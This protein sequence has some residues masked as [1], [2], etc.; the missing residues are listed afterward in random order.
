[1]TVSYLVITCA[2][3]N[4]AQVGKGKVMLSHVWV[5]LGLCH[6]CCCHESS[7][8]T[9]SS[10]TLLP[11]PPYHRITEGFVLEGSLKIT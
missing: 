7:S 8:E 5:V 3:E 4:K 2:N 11:F 10:L 9:I 6:H 1:M